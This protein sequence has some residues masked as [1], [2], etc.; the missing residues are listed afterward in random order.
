MTN[1]FKVCAR[2]WARAFVRACVC[3]CVFVCM[4]V[5]HFYSAASLNYQSLILFRALIFAYYWYTT[6]ISSL[7]RHVVFNG[8]VS[9]KANGAGNQVGAWRY[10]DLL[11]IVHLD[12]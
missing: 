7:Y 3:V 8:P 10:S 1:I 11:A 5:C 6:A 2:A 9:C 4:Y 12:N